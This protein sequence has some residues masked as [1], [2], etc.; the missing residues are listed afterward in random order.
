M[1]VEHNEITQTMPPRIAGNREAA[2]LG[3]LVV[4]VD[5]SSLESLSAARIEPIEGLTLDIGRRAAPDGRPTLVLPDGTVSG[6]HARLQRAADRSDLFVL[7]DLASTNGTFV[8]GRRILGP[9]PLS[10]G[11]VVFL[12]S[13]VLV[14]R[15]YTQAEMDAVRED[16]REPL[17][18]IPTLS[19]TLGLTTAKL[20]RLA[21]SEAEIL[22]VGET[23]VGKDVFATAVHRVSERGG[24]LMAVNC[25][26]IPR[27]LVESE[28]FGYEKGAHS[29]AQARKTGLVEAADGG[30]LFLDE[31]GEMPIELQSKLLR[32]LQDRRFSPLGSTRVIEADVR[33]VA[34]TSRLALAKGAHVQEALLGRLG[35]QP[36]L[37]LP[38][39]DRIEDLGSLT[40]HFLRDVTD[41]RTFEPDAFKALMLY[42]WPLNVRELL[43]VITEAEVLS[44]NMPTIG[45][46]H[47]PDAIGARLQV[48]FADDMEDTSVD[49]HPPVPANDRDGVVREIAVEAGTTRM[50]RRAPSRH[51]LVH[52]LGACNG[53]VAEVARRLNRQYAVVWRCIQ[54]Y[55]IDAGAYRKN[56]S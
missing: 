16:A 11:A 52:L 6:T 7:Q 49:A 3:A 23:G 9:T 18:P 12:G 44:R 4:V 56:G 41:G 27:E 37:L 29:T 43:K 36:N 26:A 13:H 39:R 38:L 48:E 50:R 28:L 21:R 51:E 1:P 34:A 10:D 42:D 53:S 20:R 19:P 33:I 40:A 14:F 35:A 5:A 47:L 24:R 17:T 55:G 15:L 31:I 8:N 2:R 22:L 46:E 54:R 32:F 45:L 30:T 25:A